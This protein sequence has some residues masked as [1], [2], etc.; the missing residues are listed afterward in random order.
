M[1]S[2]K[3]KQL[4][5]FLY[6]TIGIAAVALILL[7]FNLI[8]AQVRQR[9]DLTAEK[10]YTLSPGH[11]GHSRE[12][13]Y[14]GSDP[15]LLHEKREHHAGLP[16][17]LRAA[18]GRFARRIPAGLERP[19]RRAAVES[20][21]RFRCGRFGQA[22]WSRRSAAP[23]RGKSLSRLERRHARSETGDFVSGARP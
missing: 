16:L 18:R 17:D 19:D 9:V 3:K 4:E 13:R 8:A 14:A 2:T 12:A 7:A 11:Q 21:A 22:R 15:V 20:R 10:A 1:D 23:D 6:S 5:T